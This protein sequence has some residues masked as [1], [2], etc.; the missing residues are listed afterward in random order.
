MDMEYNGMWDKDI[1]YL[2]TSPIVRSLDGTNS[3]FYGRTRPIFLFTLSTSVEKVERL[4]WL[5]II[6]TFKNSALLLYQ[7][8]RKMKSR[9]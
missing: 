6:A 4:C 5:G 3:I 8:R 2:R 9:V 1:L 7:H